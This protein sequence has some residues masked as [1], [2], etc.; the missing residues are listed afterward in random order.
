MLALHLVSCGGKPKLEGTPLSGEPQAGGVY[1]LNDGEGGFR[2]GKV[3]AVEDEAVFINLY[4]NRWKSR[5]SRH[6]A[7][8]V[9]KPVALAYST[10]SFTSMHPLHLED[11]SVLDEELSAYERWRRSKRPMF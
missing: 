5:P 10:Q 7:K 4:E 8:G 2:V 1:S 11:G 3:I 6:I 9:E